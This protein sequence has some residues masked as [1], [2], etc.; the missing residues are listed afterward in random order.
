[1]V[2]TAMAIEFPQEPVAA[3]V[4]GVNL[5]YGLYVI[6]HRSDKRALGHVRLQVQHPA[7]PVLFYPQHGTNRGFISGF[8]ESGSQ[9]STI[10]VLGFA[11]RSPPKP[12]L[13]EVNT[14]V[15]PPE[16]GST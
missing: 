12:P 16:I 13:L 7:G 10:T 6:N 8:S 5:A 9:K 4:I 2:D 11:P 14:S 1:M 3:K 15:I